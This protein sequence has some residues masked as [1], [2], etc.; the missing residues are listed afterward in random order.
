MLDDINVDSLTIESIR[1]DE[2]ASATNGVLEDLIDERQRTLAEWHERSL[3]Q[4]S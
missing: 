1:N 3:K 2:Q 4:Q